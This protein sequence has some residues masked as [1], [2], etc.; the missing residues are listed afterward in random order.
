METAR[1]VAIPYSTIYGECDE[2][3]DNSTYALPSV[4]RF[5]TSAVSV[6]V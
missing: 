5:S 6:S 1:I 2:L 4:Q 3:K